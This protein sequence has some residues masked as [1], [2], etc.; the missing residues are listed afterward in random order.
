MFRTI[1]FK[2]MNF[3]ISLAFCSLLTC[4]YKVNANESS[5]IEV[6]CNED[7]KESTCR[8]KHVRS[9]IT[10]EPPNIPANQP[11]EIKI[12]PYIKD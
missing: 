8:N 3:Y 2:L 6:T 12:V 4:M 7:V 1:Y 10:I 11:I 5:L 9:R